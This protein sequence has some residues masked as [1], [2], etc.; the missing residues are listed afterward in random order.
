M[1]TKD[2]PLEMPLFPPWLDETIALFHGGE[3]VN[4]LNMIKAYWDNG[5]EL[6]PVGDERYPWPAIRM[7][8]DNE[9]NHPQR[10]RSSIEYRQW[11]NRVFERDGYKCR[12]C[13]Q[14]GGKLNAHHIK[15]FAK[16]PELRLD[17]NNG[18]TLCEECHRRIHN[19][20]LG[21]AYKTSNFQ[22]II[23]FDNWEA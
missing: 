16:H 3:Y 5:I 15:Y 18:I 19:G 2:K 12:A 11:R 6:K 10:I 22:Y 8:L 13:G 4:L 20:T 9:K 21:Y 1:R 17:I 7:W 14:I 23:F